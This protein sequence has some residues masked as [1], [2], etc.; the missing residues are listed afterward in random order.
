L[1]QLLAENEFDASF[2]A[3]PAVAG[4]NIILRS[5]AHLYCFAEGYEMDPQPEIADKPKAESLKKANPKASKSKP[6]MSKSMS[7]LPI[8]VTGYYMGSKTKDDGEFEA[9]FL[10]EFPDLDKDDW[11]KVTFIGESFRA[12]FA[13]LSQYHRVTINITAELAKGKME[14]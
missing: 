3:S 11:P 4:D 5:T 9:E 14:K 1:Y 12:S 13:N 10:I 7:E 2:I 6:G 8:N